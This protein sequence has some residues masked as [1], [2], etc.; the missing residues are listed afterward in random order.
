MTVSAY[1]EKADA[2]FREWKLSSGT[3]QYTVKGKTET[4]IIDHANSVFIR[5]GVVCPDQWFSQSIRPLF[6]LKEAPRWEN[7][8]DLIKD[9]LTKNYDIHKMWQRISFWT[10]GLFETTP[11]YLM[12]FESRSP[13]TLCYGNEHLK[14]IAVINVRKSDCENSSDIKIIEAY[15][16][17]DKSRLRK[18]LE[19]CDPT[20]IVCGYTAS[21][22]DSIMGY[23]VR[24]N[25]N[26]NLYYYI[27]LNNHDVLVLD[28]WHPANRYPDLMNYYGLM[29]IYQSALRNKDN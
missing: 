10:K 29:G 17:F 28:Y 26:Q 19:L 21:V 6:L 15:G 5:D 14:K 7:D 11:D 8:C 4:Q 12:P 20:I 2:L 3:I 25:E 16:E 13:D 22:L 18:Q 23:P 24:K 27:K 9:H 1:T